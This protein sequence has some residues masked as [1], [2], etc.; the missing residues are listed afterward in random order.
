MSLA[1][2][3][4]TSCA[5]ETDQTNAAYVCLRKA[6]LRGAFPANQPVSQVKLA[7]ELGVSRTPLR[8][9]LRMLQ[10]EGL[11]ESERNKRVFV[12]SLD[13]SEL[14]QIYGMRI[15][16]ETLAARISITKFDSSNLERMSRQ[17]QMIGQHL[18]I[19]ADSD[20]DSYDT[21]HRAFHFEIISKA[22]D[23]LVKSISDLHDHA[24]RYRRHYCALGIYIPHD[25]RAE[26]ASLLEA[27]ANRDAD[28]LATRLARHYAGTV[29][30]LIAQLEPT[31]DPIATRTAARQASGLPPS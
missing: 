30:G 27:C 8:E 16:L 15:N 20:Y 31:Y 19:G 9:A 29:L 18:P 22:G 12:R 21:P 14:D 11:I 1:D 24:G 17:L 25:V 3:N 13:V 6:I 23:R 7:R 4:L 2:L 10:S 5:N 28:V 26:H